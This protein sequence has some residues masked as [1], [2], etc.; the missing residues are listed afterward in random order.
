MPVPQGEQKDLLY[1]HLPLLAR[2]IRWITRIGNARVECVEQTDSP[3]NFPLQQDTS[4]RVSRPPSKST[5]IVGDQRPKT[6]VAT[7]DTP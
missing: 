7:N 5:T 2:D 3:I 1:E 6:D 4:I